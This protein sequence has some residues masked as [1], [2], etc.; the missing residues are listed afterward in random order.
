MKSLRLIFVLLLAGCGAAG[1][2]STPPASPQLWNV[3]TGGSELT[4][5]IQALDFYPDTITVHS[6]DTITWS[7][8]TSIPHTVSIPQAG[9]TPPPGPP[10]PAQVGG[11]VFDGSA[12]ISSGFIVKGKTYS[13]QFTRPGT[14][15]YY[16]LVHQ[17]EMAGT[18]VVLAPGSPLPM[19]A[20]E[21]ATVA[22]ADLLT[23]LQAG[24]SSIQ[25]F[26]YTAGGV[27]LAAGISP[28]LPGTK[29][30]Q[31][32]VMRFLDDTNDSSNNITIPVD[33][34]VTW[35]N[36]S[37]NVRHTVTFPVAGQQPPAGPPD[38]VPP[39]G[40]STYDGTTLTNSGPISPGNG[41]S[42]TFTKAGTYTYYCLFHDG[43][44]GMI[45]TVTVQ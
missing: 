3:S 37:N 14:Y 22:S 44:T 26:P 30:S 5:S 36:A 9:Q 38:Q 29:P 20:S 1:T 27:H 23:D 41:Y 40:G 24:A 45:G 8:S 18:I 28:G 2:A 16:C 34:T 17:P 10:N 25:L 6:G 39:S 13:V 19:S 42:L 15:Q 31:S 11:D 33:T 32:T 35:T 43:P 4:E 21:Y 7:N 12:Y